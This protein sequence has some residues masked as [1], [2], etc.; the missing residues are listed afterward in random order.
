MRKD[1]GQLTQRIDSWEVAMSSAFVLM[2]FDEEFDNV[3]AHFIK[4][5]LEEVGFSVDRA[6]DID[7]QQNILRDVLE[8]IEKSDLIVADLTTANPNVFYELGLA[9]ARGKPVILVTQSVED[10]PF[11]LKSY[12]LLEY[13]TDFVEIKKAKDHLSKLAKGFLSEEVKFGTPVT[14]FL[15]DG[16]GANRDSRANSSTIAQLDERGFID[17]LI[18]VTDGYN[19]IADIANGVT[20]DLQA[21]TEATGTATGQYKKIRANPSDSSP[22][23]AR[24]VSRRLAQQISQ[25]KDRL[26]KAN[27]DY[28]SI[29][30]N[31]ENSLEI[32]LSFQLEQSDVTNPEIDQQMSSLR[33]LQSLVLGS[34]DSFLEMAQKM[35]EVPRL[36]R[37]LNRELR[38]A[39][40]EVRVMANNLDKTIASIARALEKKRG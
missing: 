33:N 20:N 36:E 1:V 25:F 35:D 8:R 10:V 40:E 5:V 2:P 18:D 39:S 37:H 14:D 23:A 16:G 38:D 15:Q 11:D 28:S 22:V 24:K 3:Y 30:Q 4:P 6:D 29:A 34:R 31:T 26:K 21:L 32:V 13:S 17:H 27:A 7:S 9:H 19:R 12:R